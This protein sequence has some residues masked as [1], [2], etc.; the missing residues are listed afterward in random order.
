MFH[1]DKARGI[2]FIVAKGTAAWIRLSQEEGGLKIPAAAI[3][4]PHRQSDPAG[5]LAILFA[6]MVESR[7]GAAKKGN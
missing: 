1:A 2:A 5:R 6:N 3:A 7:A 4:Q